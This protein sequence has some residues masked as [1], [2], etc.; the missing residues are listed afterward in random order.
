[1]VGERE[2][3]ESKVAVKEEEEEKVVVREKRKRAR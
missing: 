1:M 2:G 3:K